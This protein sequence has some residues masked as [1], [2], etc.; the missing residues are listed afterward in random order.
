MMSMNQVFHG[1][2]TPFQALCDGFNPIETNECRALQDDVA[3]VCD[4]IHDGHTQA[5]VF[6]HRRGRFYDIEHVT[7]SFP[8]KWVK[9]GVMFGFVHQ[10]YDLLGSVI[11]WGGHGRARLV[12]HYVVVVF[13]FFPLRDRSF[14]LHALGTKEYNK[15]PLASKGRP[16]APQHKKQRVVCFLFLY[17]VFLCFVVYCLV[18]IRGVVTRSD[19]QGF[20]CRARRQGSAFQS[21]P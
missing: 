13:Q 18:W 4:L 20:A 6:H 3:Y 11:K 19:R 16:H 15:N 8:F 17:G 7:E 10:A 2:H 14:C 1:N 9:V 5:L 12:I 21:I